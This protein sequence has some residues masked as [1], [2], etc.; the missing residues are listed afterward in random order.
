[1]LWLLG[2]A[3]V[4]IIHIRLCITEHLLKLNQH[5]VATK[6][7]FC[8]S[9]NI[10]LDKTFCKARSLISLQETE[11]KSHKTAQSTLHKKMKFFIKDFFSNF[12]T[13][14]ISSCGFGHN[15]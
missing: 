4:I 8:V 6:L 5:E 9:K 2:Y 12:L 13:S 11:D 1:M 7:N 14:T 3:M 15:Y 10:F